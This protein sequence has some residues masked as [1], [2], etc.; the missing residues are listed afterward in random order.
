VGVGWDAIHE[1]IQ[2]RTDPPG[3]IFDRAPYEPALMLAKVGLVIFLA[4]AI[5]GSARLVTH[6]I[7]WL[8]RKR[9]SNEA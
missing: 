2:K 7:F 1:H 5:V 4:A 6:G 3:W 8:I 9:R